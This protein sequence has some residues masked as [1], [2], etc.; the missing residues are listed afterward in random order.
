MTLLLRAARLALGAAV[1]SAVIP[2]CYNAGAGTAPPT[3]TFYFPTGLAVS[4]GGNVLYAINSDFDLQWNGG[5]LQSYDLFQIRQDAVSLIQDNL[6]GSNTPPPGIP[7]IDTWQP[8]CPYNPPPPTNDLSGEGLLLGE[9][10]APAVDSTEYV[11]DSAIVGAFATDLQTSIFGVTASAVTGT[12]MA[13]AAGTRLLAP[14]SGNATVTYADVGIDDPSQPPNQ[15]V[16]QGQCPPAGMATPSSLSPFTLCCG[17]RVDDRCDAAHATG[18]DANQDNDTRGLTLPGEPFGLGQSEDG[19]AMVVTSETQTQTSLM[20]TGYLPGIATT[21]PGMQFVVNGMPN[22]G[23]S[24]A[25]V[26]HDRN[27]VTRCEDVADQTPCVRQAFLQVNR[28]ST[29]VDLLRY[30]DDQGASLIRPFLEKERSYT[31]NTNAVGSDA[32]GIAI[33]PS[34]RVA[35]EALQTTAAG[36]T[37]CAEQYPARVF[38][39]NRTPPS[40]V[41]GQIGLTSSSN[42]GTYDADALVFTS[43]VSLTAGPSKLYLAPVVMTFP[44]G[45]PHYVLRLFVVCFDTS[46]IF[47]FDPNELGNPAATPEAL[48]Y[49]G[50]GPYALAFDPFS[51][52]DVATNAVVP[53]DNRAPASL[54]LKRYRFAYVASFT[55]SY[56]QVIDLDDD[57]S[58]Q[59]WEHV[60]FTLGKPTPPKGQ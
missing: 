7:F 9:A 55:Q 3:N 15:N 1:F 51:M 38:I 28:G 10:C 33:D 25:A 6:S 50:A 13:G 35:C 36:K 2:A 53:V 21:A 43:N 18:N 29:E 11:R 19:T 46:T 4:P 12:P 42:D 52:D 16:D 24:V 34:Q 45:K 37:Q 20:T 40:I 17:T 47:V 14:I 27:V 8:N 59:T 54:A 26:P 60:V 56:L 31:I 23:V 57:A 32:R 48:I 5:T 41:V 58:P 44:D 49:T 39:A 22:G 30:Y